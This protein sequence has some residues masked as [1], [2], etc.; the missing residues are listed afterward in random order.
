MTPSQPSTTHLPE[1]WRV[2]IGSRV[3][4]ANA[5]PDDEAVANSSAMCALAK[6]GA[7]V[8]GLTVTDGEASTLSPDFSQ[9]RG[10]RS[11]V[12]LA[13]ER[14]HITGSCQHYLGL[15]DG[16]LA[17]PEV[18][19]QLITALAALVVEQHIVALFSPGADGFDGHPDHIAVD[20]A[21][22]A[23]AE[24]HNLP[25]WRLCSANEGEVHIPVNPS[26][27]RVIIAAHPSQLQVVDAPDHPF[28]FRV[29]GLRPVHDPLVYTEESYARWYTNSRKTKETS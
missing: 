17:N 20:A 9:S 24:R 29:I 18:Q 13:Y 4:F 26:E 12:A 5:H 14:C 3:L 16:A 19:Q 10:R 28:G 1:A 6:A 2:F 11:E 27:K 8:H 25:L 7:L 21:C 22:M 15:P 23:I